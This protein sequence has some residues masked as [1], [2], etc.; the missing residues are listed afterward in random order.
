INALSFED[1]GDEGDTYDYS[2]AYKDWIINLGFANATITTKVGKQTQIMLLE[3]TWHVP[4]DLQ[5]RAAKKNNGAITY[6]IKLQLDQGGDLI[7]FKMNVNNQVLDH[8]L[9]LVM[10]TGVK[11]QNTFAD[12]QFGVAQRPVIDPKM[13]NWQAIGYREEPTAL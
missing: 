3:G 12:T 13:D 6:R 10:N 11:A 2:P 1:G 9:R 5:E 4:Y 7:K 8:R